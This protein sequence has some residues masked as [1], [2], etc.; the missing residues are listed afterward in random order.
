MKK[1]IILALFLLNFVSV[2]AATVAKVNG[3]TKVVADTGGSVIVLPSLD[4]PSLS[5]RLIDLNQEYLS[6]PSSRL[7]VDLKATATERRNRLLKLAT[8]DPQAFLAAVL[9]AEQ[10]NQLIPELQLLV[11]KLSAID[12]VLGVRH[13]DVPDATGQFNVAQSYSRYTIVPDTG[14][15]YDFYPTG[16]LDWPSGTRVSL[17]QAYSLDQSLV[18]SSGQ[19]KFTAARPPQS[20]T[21][22]I[23]TLVLLVEF[24]DSPAPPV[25][26]DEVAD[27]VFAGQNRAYFD[28][29]SYGQ[30]AFVG[31]RS[32]VYGW[33]RLNRPGQTADGACRP[34][35]LGANGWEDGNKIVHDLGL[36][37]QLALRY[38]QVVIFENHP[39]MLGGWSTLGPYP[40]KL[41]NG[42]SF[43]LSD[44]GIGLGHFGNIDNYY[45]SIFQ[46]QFAWGW[47]NHALAHEL[48]HS[49][50][51]AHAN[52][53]ECGIESFRED[54]QNLEYF[55]PFDVMGFG[56][57]SLHYGGYMKEKI[58]WLK[59]T[60]IVTITRSG[61]YGLH[62]LE[63]SSG[64]RTARIPLPGLP[65]RYI[66]LEYRQPIGFDVNLG[67]ERF[68]IN[69][70]GLLLNY[71]KKR[72]NTYSDPVID[73][74]TTQLIDPSPATDDW[75][76]ATPDF[77]LH[78]EQTLEIDSGG[79]KIT[80]GP[81][82]QMEP[83][84]IS[85][86]VRIE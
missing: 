31:D 32:D 81:I 18:G 83:D 70:D 82:T 63:A 46:E 50:G 66:Y 8:A 7:L 4:L 72:F 22:E 71:V 9:P 60:D 49:L 38:R 37:Q 35:Y 53:W 84:L 30:T 51:L 5:R 79:Q 40:V 54:C 56:R 21:G 2:D 17:A 10:L 76:Y 58:G 61:R 45:R 48:G 59:G 13:F 62:P 23:K 20:T 28:E 68:S 67:N 27:L 42:S 15:A 57:A 19:L 78:E 39:C 44:V 80:I 36:D 25:T 3:K 43:L 12:G 86:M 74:T 85:F 29:Q 41:V 65:E 33:I 16:N 52:G 6:R 1:S 73:L 47:I 77:A 26:P 55:N 64:G 24:S 14:P 75:N 11:E 34:V 69:R